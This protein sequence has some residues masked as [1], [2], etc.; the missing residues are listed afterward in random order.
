MAQAVN[1][2][3]ELQGGAVIC[4]DGQILA[5]L[6]LQIGA[7]V[8]ELPIEAV[9]KKSDE[10]QQKAAQLGIPFPDA[11]LTLTTLTTPA[12]PFLRICEQGLVDI[13]KDEFVDLIVS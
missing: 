2:V 8:S 6:P 13:Q 9:A 3:G 12:I 10:V 1:R 7:V 5:E 4:A 11:H